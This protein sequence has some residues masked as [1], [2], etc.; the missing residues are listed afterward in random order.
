MRGRNHLIVTVILANIVCAY[1]IHPTTLIDVMLCTVGMIAVG[2]G[3]LAP[4]IDIKQSM[5]R[6]WYVVLPTLPF[7]ITQ[8]S[9]HWLL[10][11]IYGFKHRG[12]M[13]SLM[14]WATSFAAIAILTDLILGRMISMAICG[15]FAFGYL[16]HLI[17][18]ALT[19]KTR[20]DWIPEPKFMKHW[21]FGVLMVLTLAMLLMPIATAAD[22]DITSKSFD[23]VKKEFDTFASDV[24][25]FGV[26]LVAVYGGI[27]AYCGLKHTSIGIV[28]GLI[29]AFVIVF[30]LPGILTTIFT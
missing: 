15:G 1:L 14:G 20:I 30:V 24:F 2:F 6:K 17:E 12:V 4:D 3:S 22:T 18:D 25:W 10:G 28:K 11:T 9:V 13:H 5:I 19:T 7:W 8:L 23:D 29:I 27:L 16:A 26:K 21:A